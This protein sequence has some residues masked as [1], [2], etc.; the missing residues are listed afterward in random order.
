M[1]PGNQKFIKLDDWLAWV[2]IYTVNLGFPT[3]AS[4][5]FSPSVE[6]N[7]ALVRVELSLARWVVSLI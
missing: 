6:L 5:I 4:K 3:L 1:D 2:A 7:H